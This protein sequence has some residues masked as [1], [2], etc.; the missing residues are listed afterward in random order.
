MTNLLLDIVANS[1][2]SDE[3]NY[4]QPLHSIYRQPARQGN[5]Y[6]KDVIIFM[7]EIFDNDVKYVD[8]C[9]VKYSLINII[10]VAFH[11]NPIGGHLN[12]YCTY[13]RISQR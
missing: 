1:D 10:F 12:M 11:T 7:K 9:I 5:F 4:I 3:Q 2:L 8:L 13:Q 6:T